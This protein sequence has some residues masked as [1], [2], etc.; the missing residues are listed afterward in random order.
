MSDQSQQGSK[1]GKLLGV[2]VALI[3]LAVGLS[4]TGVLKPFD[5]SYDATL[6]GKVTIDGTLADHGKISFFPT[7]GNEV[8]VGMIESDGTYVVVPG[9]PNP[10]DSEEGGINSGEYA[11][12][13]QINAFVAKED[14]SEWDAPRTPGKSLIA[15]KYSRKAKSDLKVNVKPGP[16]TFDIK[17]EG[18]DEGLAS[19]EETSIDE[20]DSENADQ[21]NSDEAEGE[22]S[23]VDQD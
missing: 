23:T 13:A 16:N 20:T 9:R 4:V 11:V 12:T 15:A 22:E 14:L 6:T 5:R 17:L 19:E 3:V 8:F 21:I 7:D 2:L 1:I 18:P 10:V